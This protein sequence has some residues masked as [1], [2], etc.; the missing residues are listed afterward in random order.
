VRVS[1]G[2]A[3][4]LRLYAGVVLRSRVRYV[5]LSCALLDARDCVDLRVQFVCHSGFL[6]LLLSWLYSVCEVCGFCLK[7][8]SSNFPLV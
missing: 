6:G 4:R 1:L 7:Q 3:W 2:L 8:D 5:A